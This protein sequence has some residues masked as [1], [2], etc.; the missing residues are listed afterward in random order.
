MGALRSSW[1]A[2]AWPNFLNLPT[3][4]MPNFSDEQTSRDR[5][6]DVRF[7][8]ARAGMVCTISGV[9]ECYAHHEQASPLRIR[10]FYNL[11][12]LPN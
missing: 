8:M 7:G 10:A 5:E 9:F 11:W 4:A 6:G 12:Q 2:I 3:V 1:P